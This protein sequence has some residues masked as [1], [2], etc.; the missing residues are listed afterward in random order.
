MLI[1]FYTWL[2]NY[3]TLRTGENFN[4][5]GGQSRGITSVWRGVIPRPFIHTN[6]CNVHM[7]VCVCGCNMRY[8]D[9]CSNPAFYQQNR[10]ETGEKRRRRKKEQMKVKEGSPGVGPPTFKPVR[11]CVQEVGS[12]PIHTVPQTATIAPGVA[13]TTRSEASPAFWRELR[14]IQQS[15]P[16][17]FISFVAAFL[18]RLF[19]ST[20]GMCSCL[21]TSHPCLQKPDTSLPWKFPAGFHICQQTFSVS[22]YPSR[23]FTHRPAR[24]FSFFTCIAVLQ[25]W[26]NGNQLVY[27]PSHSGVFWSVAL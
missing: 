18:F 26:Q 10:Q 5:A 6:L 4:Q 19:S 8:K 11:V 16:G 22:L 17:A 2:K 12:S 27:K 23:G 3:N 21:S 7:P 14:S 24:F 15:V 25:M 9:F 13:V 1:S 20:V